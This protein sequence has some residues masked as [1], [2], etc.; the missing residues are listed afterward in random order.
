MGGNSFA[1]SGTGTVGSNQPYVTMD[2]DTSTNK[3]WWVSLSAGT[4]SEF[5]FY[6]PKPLKIE[7]LVIGYQSNSTTWQ[8]ST[9]VVQGSNDNEIWTDLAT[10]NYVS[11]IS[12][13]INV[14]SSRFF[15]YHR[16]LLKVYYCYLGIT[17]I[18]VN[19][20]YKE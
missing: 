9:I 19:A 20:Q 13:T 6:N 1:V 11:G 7:S 18:R 16:L 17:D 8:A 12:R 4:N 15:K 5:V 10:S 2:S 3:Y 14:N